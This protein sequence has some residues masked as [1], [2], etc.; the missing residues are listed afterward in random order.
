MMSRVWDG[1][2][3]I[4]WVG[5]SRFWGGGGRGK[6]LVLVFLVNTVV[7]LWQVSDADCVDRAENIL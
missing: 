3:C 1:C 6:V 4:G 5:L 7:K 2:R